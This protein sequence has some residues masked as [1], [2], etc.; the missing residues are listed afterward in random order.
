MIRPLLFLLSMFSLLSFG[1][2][3]AWAVTAPREIAN[4]NR[5]WKYK[6]GDIPGAEYPG[7]NASTWENVGIP[8]SFSMPYFLSKDF[9]VGYGWYRK[10]FTLDKAKV[11]KHV[12][13]E[14]DGVFQEAEVFVNGSKAGSHIGGYTGFS[15]DITSFVKEGNNT[16]AVRVNNEWR[17]DVAPRAGEHVFSGGIYRNVR[18]VLKDPTH[19]AWY[20][21]WVTTP[22]L[23]ASEGK[24][25]LV[26]VRTEVVNTGK[27]PESLE[28]LTEVVSG[29]QV[30]AQAK[31]TLEVK[32]GE[33]VEFDQTT[34]E[35]EAPGLWSLESPKMYKVVSSLYKGGKLV[36]SVATDF[37]FRWFK[38]TADQGFF[39][40]GKHLYFTGAN[41]HQDHAGWGDAVTD[42]GSARDVKIMKEAGFN[43]IRGSHYPHSPGFS[44]ACDEQGML[45]WSENCF[46]G[47]GPFDSPWGGSAYPPEEKYAKGFEESVKKTL[48]E[49]IRIHRNHPSI[50]AWSTSNEPFFTHPSTMDSVR[51]LLEDCVELSHQLDPDRPIAIGGCQR[52]EIDHIGDIA[53]YNGDG[54]RLFMNPGVPSVVS[55]Y[56]STIADRPGQ[57]IPGWGNLP[58][59]K[60]QD[61]S[62]PYPWR[63]PWRSGEAI[64]C[65]FDHGS[66]G[67]H[68]GCMGV[69]DYFRI[70]KRQWYWY[71]NAYLQTP[72]P[73]WPQEGK[74]AGLAL[75]SDANGTIRAD[76]TDDV[77]LTVTVVDAAGK[78]LSNNVPVTLTVESG[79]GEFPTGKS[80]TFTPPSGDQ[81]SDIVIR[82]GKAAME[83]RSYY[84]GKSKVRASSPGLKDAVLELEFNGAPAYVAGKSVETKNRPYV[85]FV[86]NKDAKAASQINRAKLGP[87]NAGSESPGHTARMANDGVKATFWQTSGQ[88]K[89]DWIKID[90]ERL[91]TVKEVALQ[92][93]GRNSIPYTVEL[94]E[95]GTNWKEIIPR[96]DKLR[97][98]A[99]GTETGRFLKVSFPDIPEGEGLKVSEIEAYGDL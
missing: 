50:V 64:W 36:D 67:G 41:V 79:P 56:G 29:D 35:V 15:V 37:G 14:F 25:S 83:L 27:Q 97:S 80:I 44:K 81:A 46:W 73:E 21:T 11:Q 10:D 43:M 47:T 18:L 62:E 91:I 3:G 22:G 93:V 28:L 92:L 75:V 6:Q 17:P 96:T 45:F 95:D 82:D 51:K 2:E 38:W 65:G 71:R 90:L 7:L 40:N 61:S 94:S 8:H 58:E 57:Y 19:I 34:P 72:P 39:L 89:S 5:G 85:R 98:Q 74:P 77:H 1:V 33:M 70:P 59:G 52:G 84:A 78:E 42:A 68:F 87:T 32:A 76:G 12:S 49:M 4:L 26:R 9:Y 63:Y 16:I 24:S 31:S 69:V 53:G 54:A 55:E 60:D 66:L 86:E 20:G 13:L 30:V 99:S 23:E 48:A 88:Q